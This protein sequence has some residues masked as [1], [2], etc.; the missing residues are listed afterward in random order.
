MESKNVRLLLEFQRY[1]LQH[2][3]ERF[4]QALLNWSGVYK[5][6]ADDVTDEGIRMFNVDTFYWEGRNS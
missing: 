6:S 4:W 2:P 1:C 5:I 3:E